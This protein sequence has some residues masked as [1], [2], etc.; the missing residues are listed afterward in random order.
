[1][2]TTNSTDVKATSNTIASK[3]TALKEVFVSATQHRAA[4]KDDAATKLLAAQN[5]D[6][7]ASFEKARKYNE[8]HETYNARL[9]DMSEKAIA[10]CA[11]LNI[12]A[13]K[14]A[15]QSRELKKRTVA[16]LEALA[17]NSKV[18]DNALDALLTRLA[19]KRDSIM[20]LEQ[21][22]REMNHKT[23]TQAQYFKTCALFFSFATYSKSEKE[24]S[25]D[26]NARVLRDL[27]KAYAI[28]E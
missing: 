20:T 6:E 23:T 18:E 5:D 27:L 28:A 9:S 26:Y 3:A 22:R 13:E 21:I 1:M 8:T 16:I 19:K 17:T 2:T 15:A 24:L 12:D 7:K 11:K 4:L 14:L 10:M 25:F